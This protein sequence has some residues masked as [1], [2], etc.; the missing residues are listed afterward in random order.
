MACNGKIVVFR[1][2]KG[3]TVK[4]KNAPKLD[5]CKLLK[6]IDKVYEGN[7]QEVSDISVL[8]DIEKKK[9]PLLIRITKNLNNINAYKYA[10]RELFKVLYKIPLLGYL[11]RIVIK[12]IKLPRTMHYLHSESARFQNELNDLKVMYGHLQQNH[13]AHNSHLDHH[14]KI[15]DANS[16]KLDTHTE[17]LDTH[18]EKLDTHT[19]KLDTHTEK[20]SMHTE[21]LDLIQET[22]LDIDDSIY[23]KFEDRFRGSQEQIKERLLAYSDYVEKLKASPDSLA[24]D[25]GCGRGEWL[26]LLRENG[27]TAKG[28][29]LNGTMAWLCNEKNLDVTHG[30]CIEFLEKVPP[31]TFDAITGFQ[32]IEHLSFKKMFHLFNLCFAALKPNGFVMFE[33]PNINN[34]LVAANLFYSDPS[35]INKLTS[36]SLKFYLGE[37]GFDNVEFLQLHARKSP[38]YTEN[39]DVNEVVYMLN[40]EQDGMLVGYKS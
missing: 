37:A 6:A 40:M 21:R 9:R 1:Q 4:K 14:A 8:Y 16:E 19:E 27:I 38:K 31:D 33:T 18:T 3:I 11:L 26:E 12:V 30:D 5:P 25:V 15:L 7:V 22:G 23:L 24:L 35:H 34:L 36:D 13:A 20:L 28:I 29:D 2:R 39:A 10:L 32:V 17:K